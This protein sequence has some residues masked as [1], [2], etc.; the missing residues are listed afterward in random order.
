VPGVAE[1]I[2]RGVVDGTLSDWNGIVAFRIGD[3]AKHHLDVPLGTAAAGV[4]MNLD[5]YNALPAAAKAVF[6]KLGGA[7]L[8]RRHGVEF[9]RQY[10]QN[11][12]ATRTKPDHTITFP[13]A[14]ERAAI[15]TKLHPVTTRWIEE[16]PDR[17][18]L[19]DAT[20]SIVEAL[21]KGK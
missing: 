19:Y 10:R 2:S 3:A 5:V 13:S 9:D 14:A 4:F 8:S 12:D 16:G 1:A 20:V 11:L 21:R 17:R 18:K 6:D 15:K 7:E